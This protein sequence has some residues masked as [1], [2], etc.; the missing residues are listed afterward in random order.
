MKKA[1]KKNWFKIIIALCVIAYVAQPY[2]NNNRYQLKEGGYGYFLFDAKS[3]DLFKKDDHEWK[4]HM[5]FKTRFKNK[6]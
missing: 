2:I 4:L 1:L 3:G 6:K 5:S